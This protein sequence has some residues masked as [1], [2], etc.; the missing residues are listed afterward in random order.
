[1]PRRLVVCLWNGPLSFQNKWRWYSIDHHILRHYTSNL[2]IHE[3][4]SSLYHGV[5]IAPQEYLKSLTPT[6]YIPNNLIGPKRFKKKKKEKIKGQSAHDMWSFFTNGH[7]N[8]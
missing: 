7:V 8:I 4:P 3:T 6:N 1:M 5:I 2:H